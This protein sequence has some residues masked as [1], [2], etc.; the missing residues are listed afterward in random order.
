MIQHLRTNAV[1]YL[2]LFIALGGTSYAAASNLPAHSV[3]ALQ[4]K[5]NAV[6]TSKVKN[7]SLRAVDFEPGQIPKGPK[8][9]TGPTWGT[10]V[11]NFDTAPPPFSGSFGMDQGDTTT[12]RT[13]SLFVFGEGADPNFV[14]TVG[15]TATWGLYVGT[16]PV[17]GTASEVTSRSGSVA[18]SGILPD[19][20]AGAY[21]LSLRLTCGQGTL[22]SAGSPGYTI[23][24]ILLGS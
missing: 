17:P 18:I 9:A 11:E 3:G 8:G 15:T 1:A 16:V 24:A 7:H 6:T 20:K 23:G 22:M 10:E 21:T 12:P 5:V 2:A 14:C 19:V 4:L 13:G